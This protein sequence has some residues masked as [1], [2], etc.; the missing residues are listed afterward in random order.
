M[1]RTR[2]SL[3]LE[4][5]VSPPGLFKVVVRIRGNSI[6]KLSNALRA[7]SKFLKD[8]GKIGKLRFKRLSQT[9]P[10]ICLN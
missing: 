8:Q 6:F 2:T 9:S 7:I 4:L 3:A 5:R 1:G 10:P